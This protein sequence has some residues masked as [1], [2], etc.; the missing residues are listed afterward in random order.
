M[1]AF[2]KVLRA[3]GDAWSHRGVIVTTYISLRLLTL[4]VLAPLL[5]GLMNWAVSLSSQSALTDQAIAGFV[6]TPVGFVASILMLSLFL[7][8]EVLGFALMTAVWR[9]PAGSLL[10]EAR[11][12]FAAVVARGRSLIVFAAL[13]VLRVLVLALPFVLAGLLVAWLLLTDYDINYYL[14]QKPPEAWIAGLAIAGLLLCLALILLVRLTGWALALHLVVFEKVSPRHSF[15]RSAELMS[16][17]RFELQR[18]VVL[19]LVIRILLMAALGLVA[20]GVLHLMPLR[21]ESGLRLV[22]AVTLAVA[23]LWALAGT[24]VSALALGALARIVDSFAANEWLREPVAQTVEKR[25]K[26]RFGL[27][28]AAAAAL[29]LFGFWSGA[30]L[31]DDISTEDDV[32]I[33]AHRGAAGSRPENTLASVRKAIEDGTDWVEIDVQETADGQ[34]VVMHD[35]DYMKLSGTDLKIWDATLDELAQI[36]IGS[37][38][39]AAYS[40]ER[41]PLLRE[42]L[43]LAQGQ[44]N[45]LIE[46]K[47]YGHNEDLENRVIAIVEDM[48]MTDQI[49]TMSLKYPLVQSML[50]LRPDWRS[51]VLAATAVGDLAGLD[52]DFIAVNTGQVS[53]WLAHSIE[54]AG[55]ELYAWT[56]NDPLEMSKMISMGVDGLITDEPALARKVLEIR[57][58]LSTAERLILWMSEELG[59]SLNEKGYRDASP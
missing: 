27:I 20:T 21:L 34:V 14:T 43:E 53:P 23:T 55:K 54:N 29:I 50:T 11:N 25:E 44:A 4:A 51:G 8:V 5:G 37:W 6:L 32:T 47:Y 19:W 41:T 13:F 48:G 46:L 15:A 42:V 36:D 35:S 31:L 57:A 18:E 24:A 26:Q 3:Y 56:V 58:E 1:S 38:F 17:R 10:A 28:G 49:A 59:L 22:L 33:I 2:S 39:D 9:G 16:G 52:G 45:V 12:A 7:L 30:R 40:E